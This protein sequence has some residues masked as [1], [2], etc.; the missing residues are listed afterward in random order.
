MG[1]MLMGE[2][3]GGMPALNG[4]CLMLA[5]MILATGCSVLNGGDSVAMSPGVEPGDESSPLYH[6]FGDVLTPRELEVDR[7]ESFIYK[8]PGFSAGV[9]TMKGRVDRNSLIAFFENN[10]PKDNWRLIS[11]FK[12]P[13]TMLLYHKENRW[14]VIN[15]SEGGLYNNTLLEVWVSP[16]MDAVSPGVMGESGLLK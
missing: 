13:R 5:L 11:L 3:D 2:R 7:S 12:S 10:M 14:C 4:L 16:T 15:I 1:G 8:S 9:L 6:D